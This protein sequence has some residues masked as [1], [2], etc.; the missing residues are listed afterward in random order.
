[1][2]EWVL[3]L[4]VCIGVG[5]MASSEGLSGVLFGSLTFLIC[6]GLIVVMPFPF[7]RILLA[8]AL[9]FV[10]LIVYRVALNK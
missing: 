7:L 4:A 2:L 3:V 5:R 6:L 10:G 8:G 9:G 1:M